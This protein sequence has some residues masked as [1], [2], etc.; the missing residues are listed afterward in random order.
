MVATLTPAGPVAATS[1]LAWR[2]LRSRL[3]SVWFWS[4]CSVT[5]L[6]AWLYG[7]GFLASFET[8]SVIVTT[9]PLLALNA[10]VVV[11]LGVVLGLRLAASMAWEREH[12]TLEVLLIGP[13]GWATII[14]AKFLV[15]IAVLSLL[16]LLY[17]AYLAMAQ[18][19][20]AGVIGLSE[21]AGLVLI[22][23][24]ALPVMAS[25]LVIGAG[26]GTVRS[27]VVV[28]LVLFGALAALE[29]AHAVLITQPVEQQSLASLYVRQALD[30]AAPVLDLVSP[31]RT[32]AIPVQALSLQVPILPAQAMRPLSQTAL[33]IV[34]AI[35]IGRIR[36]AL[37]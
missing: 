23:I 26:L 6:M 14:C 30:L 13:V 22:P 8:E 24:F 25:G 33:L 11:F 28:F 35:I 4:V 20:G 10:L 37:R 27:A 17:A 2:E 21:Q 5:C 12:R 1:L 18:P 19:L 9:D 7:A 3:G 29:I 32:L 15:E 36:G 34:L 16:V 31:V